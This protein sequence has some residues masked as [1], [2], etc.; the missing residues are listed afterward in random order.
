MLCSAADCHAVGAGRKGQSM[1]IQRFIDDINKTACVLSVRKLPDGSFGDIRI[2]TG[3]SAYIDSV[4]ITPGM[5]ETE[6]IPGEPYTRYLQEDLNFEDFTVRSAVNGRLLHSCVH[7]DR[8]DFWIN[9]SWLPMGSDEKDVY[10]CCY[11]MEIMHHASA[12]IMTSYSPDITSGVLNTCVKLH[13]TDDFI[14]AMSDAVK[15]IRKISG[16]QKCGILLVD[17]ASKECMIIGENGALS[18]EQTA[19]AESMGRSL[20]ETALAWKDDIAGSDCL[21]LKDEKTLEVIKERDPAWYSSLKKFAVNSLVLFALR[22]NDQSVGFIWA[23]NFNTEDVLR[24]KETLE[25]SSFFIADVAANHSLLRRLEVMSSI[26]MLTQLKNRNAM[27]NRVDSF[28]TGESRYPDSLGIVFAD[29]NGLKAVNDNGGHEAGD[30]LLRRASEMLMSAFNGYEIY[31]AGG[32][33]FMVICASVTQNELEERVKQLR[34]LSDSSDNVRFAV[35][36]ALESG[37]IDIHRAMIL[38]DERMYADK[39]EYYRRHPEKKSRHT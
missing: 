7:A 37:D 4:K 32:D 27:N 17:H 39:Q 35:G 24:I 6:F 2:E 13:R 22:N 5:K 21:I 10:Y 33:E 23:T 12:E 18:S 30:R 9:S 34:V 28:V 29:L 1:D 8:F 38:A 3:N 31:R 14:R 36:F 20:Y 19:I 11:A 26:D 25:L 16:A 15:D